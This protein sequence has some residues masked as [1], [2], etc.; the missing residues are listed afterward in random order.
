MRQAE[1]EDDDVAGQ[2]RSSIQIGPFSCE[3]MPLAMSVEA[4]I[5][6]GCVSFTAYPSARHRT[7]ASVASKLSSHTV[8]HAAVSDGR[9]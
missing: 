7:A 8:P 5:A 4:L 3:R 6:G 9:T 1:S 2:K